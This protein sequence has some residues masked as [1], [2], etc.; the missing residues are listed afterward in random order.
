MKVWVHLENETEDGVS[1]QNKS[2]YKF[3]YDLAQFMSRDFSKL[4]ELRSKI[5]TMNLSKQ[6][7]EAMWATFQ[8][9]KKQMIHERGLHEGIVNFLCSSKPQGAISPATCKVIYDI[10]TNWISDNKDYYE[11][12]YAGYYK[13]NIQH[14]IRIFETCLLQGS[15][16]DVL[17]LLF[18]A[19][20]YNFNLLFCE[21]K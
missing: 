20:Q 4:Y 21:E 3:K 19:Y 14:E 18:R 7:E 2:F 17:N 13:K 5:P 9:M 11:K 6:E 1:F 12:Y 10:I 8:S 15:M 16:K